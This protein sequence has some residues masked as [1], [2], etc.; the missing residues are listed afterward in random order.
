MHIEYL[1]ICIGKKKHFRFF[2]YCSTYIHVEILQHGYFGLTT[3]LYKYCPYRF[4]DIPPPNLCVITTL[5]VKVGRR[6]VGK[7]I[8]T[9]CVK[10]SG[11]SQISGIIS[12][13]IFKNFTFVSQVIILLN[14]VRKNNKIS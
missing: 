10:S 12:T 13:Q 1:G 7:Y 4:T 14:V 11:E 3:V 9:T 5:A 6:Y 2:K 8:R